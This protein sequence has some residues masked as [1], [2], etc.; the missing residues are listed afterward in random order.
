MRRSK[1]VRIIRKRS[2]KWKNRI[3]KSITL[4][5]VILSCV[6]AVMIESEFIVIPILLILSLLWIAVFVYVNEDYLAKEGSMWHK[7]KHSRIK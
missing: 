4:L 3:L 6:M 1:C 2:S 7:K 5:A